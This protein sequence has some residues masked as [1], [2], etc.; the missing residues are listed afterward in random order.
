[1]LNFFG[2][3]Q[4]QVEII[5]SVILLVL[6]YAFGVHGRAVFFLLNDLLG[7]CLS[8]LGANYILHMIYKGLLSGNEI[9]PIV[10]LWVSGPVLNKSFRCDIFGNII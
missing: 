8:A 7:F 1:M 3:D 4:Y 6:A 9:S 10:L 5:E 2:I